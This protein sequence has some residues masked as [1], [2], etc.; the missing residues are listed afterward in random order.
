MHLL[1]ACSLLVEH[2]NYKGIDTHG[3][4][5]HRGKF[6]IGLGLGVEGWLYKGSIYNEESVLSLG[7]SGLHRF[8]IGLY[9][10]RV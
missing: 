4:Y 3:A 1:H 7:Y 5:M 8:G 6:I 2:Q 9:S 10:G